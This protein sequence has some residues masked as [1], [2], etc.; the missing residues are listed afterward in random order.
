ML[1]QPVLI[2][3][4]DLEVIKACFQGQRFFSDSPRNTRVSSVFEL[5]E[6]NE[7]PLEGDPVPLVTVEERVR[8]GGLE[9]RSV[10]VLQGVIGFR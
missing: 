8:R 1:K 5:G 10:D 3:W 6:A 9:V 7:Y 2:Y 4:S